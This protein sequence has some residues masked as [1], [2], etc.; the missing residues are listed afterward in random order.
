MIYKLT[1]E[2]IIPADLDRVWEFFATPANLNRM[3]PD[4]MQFQMLSG[5][6]EPMYP[7]QLIEYKIQL[8]PGI[9]TRW[10]TEITQVRPKSYFIDV[11]HAGPYRFW[12]HIHRFE[13]VEAGVRMQDEVTYI[14]PFGWLGDI[15]HAIWVKKQLSTIFAYRRQAVATMFTR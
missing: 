2:Q 1:Q 8:M 5:G 6:N 13:P 11:Q 9:S 14:L 15:V 12:H 10:L 4:A 7:G 3:T